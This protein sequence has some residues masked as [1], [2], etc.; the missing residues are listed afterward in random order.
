MKNEKNGQRW[1]TARRIQTWLKTVGQTRA[2]SSRVAAPVKARGGGP[3]DCEDDANEEDIDE[4]DGF[5]T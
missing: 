4:E 3:N 2:N 1:N 5:G